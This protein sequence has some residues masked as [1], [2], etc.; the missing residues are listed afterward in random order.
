MLKCTNYKADQNCGAYVVII[1]I[2]IFIR[3]RSQKLEIAFQN[4]RKIDHFPVEHGR[5]H[6]PPG[7][8]RFWRLLW[9]SKPTPPPRTQNLKHFLTVL[10]QCL[11]VF[12]LIFVLVFLLVFLSVFIERRSSYNFP[13]HLLTFNILF[14]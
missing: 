9:R 5:L 4:F 3:K 1:Y 8:K 14:F 7:S 2:Y 12:L 10:V 11:L 6:S 13:S